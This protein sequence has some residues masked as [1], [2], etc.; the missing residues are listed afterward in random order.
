MIQSE[1]DLFDQK[2]PTKHLLFRIRVDCN[3]MTRHELFSVA[4]ASVAVSG[5]IVMETTLALLPTVVI[6][7]AN[8]LTEWLAKWLSAVSFVSIPNLLLGRYKHKVERLN[9]IL[10]ELLFLR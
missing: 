6:Y 4:N 7:R 8:K 2:C 5:T 3:A 9:I 10:K 1:I